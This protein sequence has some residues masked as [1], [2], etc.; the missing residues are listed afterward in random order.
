[1]LLGEFAMAQRS[2]AS[3][4]VL[5]LSSAQLG[6]WFAQKINPSSPEYNIGGYIEIEGSIDPALFELALQQVVTET[7]T[8]R[9]QITERAGKPEQLIGSLPVWSM[10]LIDVSTESDPRA[11]SE[12]WDE[13]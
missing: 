1:M 7:D 9:V 4:N 11:A 2:V 13:I 6:I 3:E 12:S 10:P 8:L 5:P